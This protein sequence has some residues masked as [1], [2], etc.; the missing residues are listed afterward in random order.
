MIRVLVSNQCMYGTA[1]GLNDQSINQSIKTCVC[2]C[3]ALRN[4]IQ[5]KVFLVLTTTATARICL[6]PPCWTPE[7]CDG[8]LPWMDPAGQIDGMVCSSQAKQ[9]NRS[10]PANAPGW[11]LMQAC[12]AAWQTLLPFHRN[13]SWCYWPP[14]AFRN[15]NSRIVRPSYG[16]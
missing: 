15:P 3:F 9:V 13:V 14:S 2:C 1:R 10:V 4:R 8:A 6:L 7:R 5:S 16:T 12:C 11:T